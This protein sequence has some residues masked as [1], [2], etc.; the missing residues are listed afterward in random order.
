[1]IAYIV[2]QQEDELHAGGGIGFRHKRLFERLTGDTCLVLHYWEITPE[3]M[4]RLRP[5]A[6]LISGFSRSFHQYEARDLLGINN[7]VRATETSILGLCGGYQLIGFIFNRDLHATERLYDEP[8]RRLRLGEP[9]SSGGYA[10]GFYMA[11]G[12]FDVRILRPHPLF[13]GL[14]D[15]VNVME[16]HYCEVKQ[17]P[18]EF[19]VLASSLECHIEV[20]GHRERPIFATAFHPEGFTETHPDGKRILENFFRIAGV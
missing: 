3:L 9:E 1:M 2:M 4:A 20:M 18:P 7:W 17:V 12:F 6:V 8:M 11:R 19:E 14:G 10:P 13:A 5:E 16:S 15:T